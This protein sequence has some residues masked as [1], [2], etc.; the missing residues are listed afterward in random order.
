MTIDEKIKQFEA[1]VQGKI[2]CIYGESGSGKS[3]LALELRTEGTIVLDGDGV[4]R[5]VNTD[6]GYS[7]EDRY[8]NNRRI[9]SMALFLSRQGFDVIISTVRA[10]IAYSLLKDKVAEITLIKADYKL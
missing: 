3:H 8:E 10:D 4:R 5:Y 6:L 9:A 7:D 1:P 2:T